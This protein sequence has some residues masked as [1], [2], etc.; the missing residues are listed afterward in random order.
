MS[1]VRYTG[2]RRLGSRSMT[3][4]TP[5]PPRFRLFPFATCRFAV[6]SP[7]AL[8][9]RGYPPFRSISLG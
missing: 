8:S 5:F 4:C 6:T 3:T 2:T 9:L 7:H 1:W